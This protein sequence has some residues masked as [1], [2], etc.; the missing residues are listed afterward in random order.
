M[1]LSLIQHI[2]SADHILDAA[3]RLSSGLGKKLSIGLLHGTDRLALQS[4]LDAAATVPH[5]V[6]QHAV[7]VNDITDICQSLEISFLLIQLT[8]S[9]RNTVGRLLRACR[10]LRIPYV[11]YK[12]DYGKLRLQNVIVPV[13]FLQEE[14]EKAQFAAAFGRFCGSHITLLQANDYGSRAATNVARMKELLDKFNFAYTTEKARRDSFKVE[15]DAMEQAASRGAGMI[16]VSASREYGLDDI[17]FGPKE[18]HLIRRSSVP[19]L[20]VNPRADLYALCD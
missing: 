13:S 9:S 20:L 12:N 16:I 5:L 14:V 19:V 15:Y 3:A 6:I 17:L 10:E 7:G 11:F 2:S 8:D 4:K 1:I 18:L